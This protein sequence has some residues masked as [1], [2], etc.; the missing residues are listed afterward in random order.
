MAGPN[1]LLKLCTPNS[2]AL[3]RPG[4]WKLLATAASPVTRM[5]STL[6]KIQLSSDLKKSVMIMI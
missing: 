2:F 5:M 4:R 6:A 3:N 1:Q